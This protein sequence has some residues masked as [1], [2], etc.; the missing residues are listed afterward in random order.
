MTPGIVHGIKVDYS[1]DILFDDLGIKRLQESYMR[2]DEASPQER[3][4]Y[5]SKTFGSNQEHSQED[6]H[7][8]LLV[9]HQYR[10]HH[11]P[12][13]QLEVLEVPILNAI[14]RN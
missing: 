9:A 4:A 11:H 14:R 12:E 1:R 6:H 3:F 2:E 8:G 7:L 5:V 10:F 13:T